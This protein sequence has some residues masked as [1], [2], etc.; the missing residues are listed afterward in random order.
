VP[1]YRSDD[2]PEAYDGKPQAQ[3]IC[4]TEYGSA[5]RKPAGPGAGA[6]IPGE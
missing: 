6:N 2:R 3:N 1:E 4:A 5:D